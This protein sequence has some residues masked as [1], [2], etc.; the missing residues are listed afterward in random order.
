MS[1]E[2]AKRYTADVV[3]LAI[4][5]ERAVIFYERANP[6]QFVGYFSYHGHNFEQKAYI[7]EGWKPQ[8]KLENDLKQ[9]Y[10]STKK[11]PQNY[12]YGEIGYIEKSARG[13]GI[14]GKFISSMADYI[15]EQHGA[16]GF[17]L[18]AGGVYIVNAMIKEGYELK[19]TVPLAEFE[20]NGGKPYRDIKPSKHFINKI[21]AGYLLAKEYH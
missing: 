2:E 12:W 5:Q 17:Y 21:P 8:V 19:A 10:I 9:K 18:F 13:A 1:Y 15:H 16:K 3:N 6:E 7:C 20:Y 14:G 11:D 4:K